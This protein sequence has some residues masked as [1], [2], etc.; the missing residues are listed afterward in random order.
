LELKH[1]TAWPR[2]IAQAIYFQSQN[3]PLGLYT[4][5]FNIIFDGFVTLSELIINLNVMQEILVEL[6]A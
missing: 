3:Q 4:V 1:Q 2:S 6:A 5:Y